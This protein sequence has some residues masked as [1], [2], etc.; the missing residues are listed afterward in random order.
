MKPSNVR[1]IKSDNLPKLSDAHVSAIKQLKEV[2][3]DL[4]KFNAAIHELKVERKKVVARQVAMSQE[5]PEL[6]K[7]LVTSDDQKAAQNDLDKFRGEFLISRDRLADIDTLL[8]NHGKT[9][10]ELQKQEIAAEEN[11][12]RQQRQYWQTLFR[13]EEA[14]LLEALRSAWWRWASLRD[15]TGFVPPGSDALGFVDTQTDN[16]GLTNTKASLVAQLNTLENQ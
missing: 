5:E 2:Q 3:A 6:L 13:E 15:L 11:L 8:E 12:Q 1:A 4:Q 10:A 16:A 9:V 7:A 14:K